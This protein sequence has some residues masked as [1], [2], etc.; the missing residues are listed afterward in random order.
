MT[1]NGGLGKMKTVWLLMSVCIM[2][3][4]LVSQA[5]AKRFEDPKGRFVIDIPEGCKLTETSKQE[6]CEQ[7]SFENDDMSF[8]IL[9]WPGM[10]DSVQ[11]YDLYE[12]T[13]KKQFEE[14]NVSV[15][16]KKVKA[17]TNPGVLG[18]YEGY[19]IQSGLKIHLHAL[20]GTASL[21]QGGIVFFAF[22][23]E[24]DARTWNEVL[25]NMFMTLRSPE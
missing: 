8:E 13:L 22:L 18:E 4:M 9:Y 1:K 23:T 14:L 5:S 7:Y 24:E 21:K 17:N 19:T 20:L 6:L 3:A 10:V 11:F 12:K 16:P 25:K 2:T 15:P